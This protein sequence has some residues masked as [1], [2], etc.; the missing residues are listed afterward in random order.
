VRLVP[1]LLLFA[2][3]STVPRTAALSLRN[4]QFRLVSG[5]AAPQRIRFQ[6][7]EAMNL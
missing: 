7:E 1:T 2:W 5:E 3:L 6:G 4:S